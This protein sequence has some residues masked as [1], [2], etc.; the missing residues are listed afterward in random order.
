MEE[1]EK[2]LEPPL[3]KAKTNKVSVMGDNQKALRTIALGGY[4]A[5]QTEQAIQAAMSAGQV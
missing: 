5:S 4:P 2:G 3:K 1:H